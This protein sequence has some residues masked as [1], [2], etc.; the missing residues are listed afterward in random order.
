VP[1]SGGGCTAGTAVC[2]ADIISRTALTAIPLIRAPQSA[3]AGGTGFQPQPIFVQ[4]APAPASASFF[5]ADNLPI[6]LLLGLGAFLLLR[7]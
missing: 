7:K 1:D 6:L 4:P 3:F 2:I 5:S